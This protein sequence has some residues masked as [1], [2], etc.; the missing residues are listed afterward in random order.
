MTH[1]PAS[2]LALDEGMY[3]HGMQVGKKLHTKNVEMM[4]TMF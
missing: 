3:T 1:I 4:Q 2:A